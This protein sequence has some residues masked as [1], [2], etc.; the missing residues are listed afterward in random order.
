MSIRI[1]INIA[2]ILLAAAFFW[3]KLYCL[4]VVYPEV[5]MSVLV[6]KNS[7]SFTS[8]VQSDDIDAYGDLLI[9][10]GDGSYPGDFLYHAIA[11]FLWLVM[12]LM[13]III[14]V[15]WYLDRRHQKVQIQIGKNA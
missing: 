9:R 1:S 5:P 8:Y 4:E 14:N 13:I 3:V 11:G 2:L 12:P 15:L 7:P 10:A 6:M